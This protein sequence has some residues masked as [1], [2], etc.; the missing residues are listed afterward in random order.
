MSASQTFSLDFLHTLGISDT[1]DGTST[2]QLHFST[3]GSDVKE[4]F[5]PVDGKLIGKISY[6]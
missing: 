5:S 3:A 4:I 2:G 6:T 1:N